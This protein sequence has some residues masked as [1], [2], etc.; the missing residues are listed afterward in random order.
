MSVHPRK[1]SSLFDP[2]ILKEAALASVKPPRA[3]AAP[4]RSG[5]DA[6]MPT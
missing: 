2:H 4:A 5:K 1:Q 6:A 3:D